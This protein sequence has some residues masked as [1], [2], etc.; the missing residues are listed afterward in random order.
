MAV[1][2]PQD[3]PSWQGVRTREPLGWPHFCILARPAEAAVEGRASLQFHEETGRPLRKA[4]W[5]ALLLPHYFC[6]P[7]KEG[8]EGGAGPPG[9]GVQQPQQQQ[10]Q[11]AQRQGGGGAA[12]EGGAGPRG[13]PSL[14]GR[15]HLATM[16]GGLKAAQEQ[17]DK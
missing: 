10:Q 16:I 1:A 12:G 6:R 7:Q 14:S 11:Q 3:Q 15:S 9:A 2:G 8:A 17:Q 13:P 4:S 5:P